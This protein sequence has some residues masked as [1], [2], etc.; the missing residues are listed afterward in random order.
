MIP[1]ALPAYTGPISGSNMGNA[2]SNGAMMPVKIPVR[3]SNAHILTPGS[4]SQE[5]YITKAAN[6]A[7]GARNGLILPV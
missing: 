5:V 7:T 3:A 1:P 2:I 6:K 4:T